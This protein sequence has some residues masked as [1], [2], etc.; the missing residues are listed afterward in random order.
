MTRAQVVQYHSMFL[1]SL[2]ECFTIN[3]WNEVESWL[4]KKLATEL[5]KEEGKFFALKRG[6][7][8]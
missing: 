5:I 3:N 6:K 1:R 7:I 4:F 8:L 2:M